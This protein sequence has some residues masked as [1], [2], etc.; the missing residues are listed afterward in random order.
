MLS[1][2]RRLINSKAGVIV[3]FVVLGVI[4]LAFGLGDVTGI[5]NGGGGIGADSVA[6]VGKEKITSVDLRQRVQGE[7]DG[8]RQ[9]QPTLDMVQF[10]AGG[11]VEG[12]LERSISAL[13]FSEY[14]GDQGMIASK[15]LVD[16][17]IASLPQTH[18]IDGKFSQANYDR[19]LAQV[20]M[21]D[22]QV[23]EGIAQDT[24]TQHL[25]LPTLRAKQVPKGLALP[26]ASLQLEKRNGLIGFIATPAVGKGAPPTDAEL[27]TFYKR[28]IARYTVPERRVIRYAIVTP[29]QVKASATPTEA[30]IAKAY[31]AQSAK[32]QP[33][34][35]RT[36]IQVVVAD[37][38]AATALAAKVKAGTP[39][40]AAIRAIGLE[41][42]KIAGVE[43]AAYAGQSSP[44][45]ANA[46]FAAPKGGV[47]GPL[48]SALGYIV[49]R[50]DAV[51]KV[52]GKTLDQAKPELA[53]ALTTEKT[54]VALSKIHDALDDAISNNATFDE[55]VADQK[56][57]AKDTPPLTTAG[58]NPD[59]PASKPDPAFAQAVAAGFGAE[60]GDDPQLVQFGQDGSFGIVS[61]ARIVPAAPRPA[62]A[63]RDVLTR[64]F[65]IERAQRVARQVAVDVA[66]KVNKGTPLAQALA[67]TKLS[68][69]APRPIDISRQQ[70]SADPR[71]APAPLVLLFNMV[72]KR[73]KMLEAPNKAGWFVIYLNHIEHGN[74]AGQEAVIDSKRAELAATVGSEYVRQLGE[75]VRRQVGVKKND[76]AIAQVKATLTGQGDSN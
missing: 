16:G 37:Q 2:I 13:A 29:D 57:Q 54:T 38:A 15:R 46:V 53:K 11:G 58:V 55:I 32:F 25:I 48:R 70:L 50:V 5:R 60:Q 68:L 49:A 23:R 41:P 72:E 67:E 45:I 56:L 10:V 1:F 75:A 71:G 74:A 36:I 34:E 20:R 69:P 52:P 51:E 28:N 17:R 62:A 63:I 12:T 9:Q 14:A 39:I 66:A 6:T 64:D 61:L 31:A 33:T 43:K 3:T 30:E 4:A 26:Y 44:E 18:G 21:T 7:L 24:L 19:L 35:K 76:K 47:V 40:D 27:S 22:A 8:A 65:Y 59:D 42:N 73:A